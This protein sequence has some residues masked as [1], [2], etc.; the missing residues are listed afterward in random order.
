MAT[1]C[2][3]NQL[4]FQE[5]GPFAVVAGFEGGTITSDVGGLLLREIDIIRGFVGD[6]AKCLKDYRDSIYVEESAR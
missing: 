6:F 3:E 4:Y 1:Q 2:I 5:L